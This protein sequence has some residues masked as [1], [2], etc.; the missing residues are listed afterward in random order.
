VQL[1]S[2]NCGLKLG[3]SHAAFVDL[4]RTWW[5]R[6]CHRQRQVNLPPG[7]IRP[8][9]VEPNIADEEALET[10]LRRLVGNSQKKSLGRRP[11]VL[12]LPDL[13]VRTTL[14][15]LDVIPS[16]TL[17]LETLLRWRLEREAFFPMTGTR[18]TWQV[19]DPRTVL[20]VAIRETVIK[21]YEEVCEAVGLLPVEVDTATFRLCNL[22]SN[23]LPA[24]EPMAWLSLLDDGFTLIIFWAGRP[25]L[26]RTKARTYADPEGLFQDIANSLTLLGEGHTQPAPRRLILFAEEPGSELIQRL[27]T[28][29]GLEVIQP[30][31]SEIKHA[32]WS[33]SDS[34][35][36]VSSLAA[37]AGLLGAA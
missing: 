35:H 24:V 27:S 4:S 14:I 2:S 25:A 36:Q 22:F 10:Q 3:P 6:S 33:P 28:E 32:G 26:V 11:T 8:S 21:Q 7:L 18:L 19:L 9:P 31:W 23:L 17:E 20:T 12:V 5:G 15:S 29:L 30:G 13:C 16:R 37:V 1:R 34:P